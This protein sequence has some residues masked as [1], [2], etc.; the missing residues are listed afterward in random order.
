MGSFAFT[1]CVSGLPIEAGTP[2]RYLTLTQTNH[3]P[4]HWSCY[5]DDLWVVR[6]FPIKAVY[7]DY[8]SIE[9]IEGGLLLD[10]FVEGLQK[11]V[12]EV[13]TGDNTCHDVPVRRDM[14]LPAY[15]EALWEGRVRVTVKEKAF[16]ISGAEPS[17]PGI[18]TLQRVR[19]IIQ[20]AGLPFAES[21]GESGYLVDETRVDFVRVRWGNSQDPEEQRLTELQSRLSQYATMISTGTGRYAHVAELTV[22]PKPL[23]SFKAE[24]HYDC[25]FYDRD[26][27]KGRAVAQ[28]MIREDVWQVLC[29]M[30]FSSWEEPVTRIEYYRQEARRYWAQ[31]CELWGQLTQ[32]QT[33]L[34]LED[35]SALFMAMSD[36]FVGHA[37]RRRASFGLAE[38]VELAVQR[39][40][41]GKELEQFLDTIGELLFIQA[42]LGSLRYQWRPASANGPQFGAWRLHSEWLRALG[43]LAEDQVP[44]EEGEEADPNDGAEPP[45]LT[46]CLPEEDEECEGNPA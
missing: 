27:P 33:P 19:S 40:P 42:L 2:V 4:E 25:V 30:G 22:A 21:F 16:L 34:S 44:S 31:V 41:E 32:R 24:E 37:I 6:S 45:A 11:S 9:N 39:K 38:H 8:G 26:Q 7:N 28:A 29:G 14:D 18:P 12:V 23:S 13:G 36:S 46:F 5:V 17:H 3:P 43:R 20:E 10:L 35:R 1:C 15:L